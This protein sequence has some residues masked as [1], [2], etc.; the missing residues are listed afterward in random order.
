[1]REASKKM[2]AWNISFDL[3][4]GAIYGEALDRRERCDGAMRHQ[5]WRI[6]LPR[7]TTSMR[8]QSSMGKRPSASAPPCRLYLSPQAAMRE[9]VTSEEKDIYVVKGKAPSR[10]WLELRGAGLR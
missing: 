10:M 8:E 1:M 7:E 4:V 3:E 2:K 5:I 9:S 6:M